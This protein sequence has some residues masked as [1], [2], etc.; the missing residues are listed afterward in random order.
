MHF[1]DIDFPN[2]I[3][4]SA[5]NGSLVI[6]AGAGVSMQ[7]G[8]RLPDFKQLLEQIRRIVDPACTISLFDSEKETPEHYLGRLSSCSNLNMNVHDACA[9]VITEC[10]VKGQAGYSDLHTQLL[11]LAPSPEQ[12]KIVTTNFDLCIENAAEE[13][14]WNRIKRYSAPALPVGKRFSGIVHLHGNRKEPDYQVLT[15]VDYGRAYVT[16][17]WA[18]RFLVDVFSTWTVL[19]IGYSCGDNLVD[20]LTRS[21][22]ADHSTRA[23]VLS[24]ESEG[25]DEWRRRGVTPIRY[26]SHG[27][28][29]KSI[30]ELA[31]YC[32]SSAAE[33]IEKTELAVGN[34]SEDLNIDDEFLSDAFNPVR[35]ARRDDCLFAFLRCATSSKCLDWMKSKR[36]L[37]SLASNKQNK[38]QRNIQAWAVRNFAC[39]E[40]EILYS[41]QQQ[42][43]KFSNET[44]DLILFALNSNGF[45]DGATKYW[46]AHFEGVGYDPN[47]FF[48][49]RLL[50]ATES[51]TV[52]LSAIRLMTQNRIDPTRSSWSSSDGPSLIMTNDAST[53]SIDS[54]GIKKWLPQLYRSIWRFL[55]PR[56]EQFE[57]IQT[58]NSKESSFS[59]SLHRAAIEPHEQDRYHTDRI[60]FMIDLARESGIL[61]I[62]E[63]KTPNIRLSFFGCSSRHATWALSS[64]RERYRCK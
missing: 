7:E 46:I 56:I 22:S 64:C 53:S 37:G 4:D 60:D 14:G 23:Y 36:F 20:Y 54:D 35:T 30:R 19:F 40:F 1:G 63:D 29:P 25:L 10:K 12:I 50:Q 24:K 8:A 61:L 34:I 55:L 39:T 41:T 27:E 3:I 31:D 9:E 45:P 33:L 47:P 43:G 16:E 21:I 5:L 42:I 26:S 18:S 11:R 15:D 6:F 57:A 48:L 62:R 51:P 2:E 17:S 58:H 44:N 52:A 59:I 32:H 49:D 28:L 13:Q 38:W